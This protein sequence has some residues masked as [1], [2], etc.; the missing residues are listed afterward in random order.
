MTMKFEIECDDIDL[1]KLVGKWVYNDE[2]GYY[3]RLEARLSYSE[4]KFLNMYFDRGGQDEPPDD[5]EQVPEDPTYDT[6]SVFDYVRYPDF[7]HTFDTY[8]ELVAFCRAR[9]EDEEAA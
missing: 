3:G 9:K 2:H 7:Y 4:F 5:V 1:D 8:A 6:L